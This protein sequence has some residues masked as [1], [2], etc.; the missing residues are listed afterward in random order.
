MRRRLSFAPVAA[1][2][3]LALVSVLRPAPTGAA[4]P[5]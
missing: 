3:A 2:I 1:T 4:E 5:L